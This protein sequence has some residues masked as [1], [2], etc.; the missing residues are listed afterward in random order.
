MLGPICKY[1]PMPPSSV[2]AALKKLNLGVEY[3]ELEE[4]EQVPAI[5]ALWRKRSKQTEM[6][7]RSNHHEVHLNIEGRQC[8]KYQFHE[9]IIEQDGH[10]IYK[11]CRP[12][13]ANLYFKYIMKK[14]VTV[15]AVDVSPEGKF[16]C[17]VIGSLTGE[18]VASLELTPTKTI[19][20]AK[21]D[22]EH[23]MQRNRLLIGHTVLEIQNFSTHSPNTKLKNVIQPPQRDAKRLKFT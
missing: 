19:A 3:A 10:I 11:H 22:I 9:G 18:E 12:L 15:E 7:V 8:L 6:A 2:M 13:R 17:S 14:I 5:D 21:T 20:W 4:N 23:F 16:V 1:S